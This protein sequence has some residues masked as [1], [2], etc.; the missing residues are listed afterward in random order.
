MFETTNV[1]SHMFSNR[2]EFLSPGAI[3]TIM[4]IEG[5]PLRLA[6]RKGLFT[7]LPTR[8]PMPPDDHKVLI[9]N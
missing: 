5:L 1:M 6:E 7:S 3:P 2:L 4:T 9:K 8:C